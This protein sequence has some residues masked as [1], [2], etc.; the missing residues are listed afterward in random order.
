MKHFWLI[1]SILSISF[2]S[3]SI[4]AGKIYKWK[5]KNG[6]IHFSDKPPR[7]ESVKTESKTVEELNTIVGKPR[8]NDSS[9]NNSTTNEPT[10]QAISNS[11]IS[12]QQQPK[13]GLSE[14]DCKR[15]V[16]NTRN[17]IP[18]LKQELLATAGNNPM[19]QALLE[20]LDSQMATELTVEKCL[21]STGNDA[22]SYKCMVTTTNIMR[23]ID[24]MM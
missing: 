6:K 17:A 9:S 18:Q 12:T 22:K 11:R 10:A 1:L 15:S 7:D 13:N 19:T 3:T 5:D 24:K 4:E 21:T 16:A 14:A 8:S 2:L 20:E 23:C